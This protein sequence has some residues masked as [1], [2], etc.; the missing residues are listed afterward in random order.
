MNSKALRQEWAWAIEEGVDSY[1]W[2][3][4]ILEFGIWG[5]CP[6]G[7]PPLGESEKWVPASSPL[8]A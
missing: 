2:C 4:H 3:V 1:S 6:Q 5:L 8:P 7:V